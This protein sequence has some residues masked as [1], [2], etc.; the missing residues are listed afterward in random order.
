VTEP[1]NRME[2]HCAQLNQDVD[3]LETEPPTEAPVLDAYIHIFAD[4]IKLLV[5][6]LRG[7]GAFEEAAKLEKAAV[8]CVK[9]PSVRK[10]VLAALSSAA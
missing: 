8:D 1:F 10:A 3:D 4:R 2:E 5:G 9:S 6:M 7:N